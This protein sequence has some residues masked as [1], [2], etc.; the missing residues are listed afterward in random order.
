VT[1]RSVLPLELAKEAEALLHRLSSPHAACGAPGLPSD[2]FRDSVPSGPLMASVSEG[3]PTLFSNRRHN[4]DCEGVLR[5]LTPPSR[6]ARP[7]GID[8]PIAPHPIEGPTY[9][10]ALPEEGPPQALAAY[11]RPES[12]ARRGS[13]A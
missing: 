8:R 1:A 13:S 6:S 3:E 4:D 7:K 5:V 12:S 2:G 9:A 11:P 10:E